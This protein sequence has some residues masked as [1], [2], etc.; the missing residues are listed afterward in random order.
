MANLV[1][2]VGSEVSAQLS[3]WKLGVAS[4]NFTTSVGEVGEVGEVGSFE[5]LGRETEE[6]SQ[7]SVWKLGVCPLL[8]TPTEKASVSKLI[9][10]PTIWVRNWSFNDQLISCA[11]QRHFLAVCSILR[12]EFF[13]FAA[14]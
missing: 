8:Y 9:Y 14:T 13:L 5:G 6:V 7:L 2:K 11:R 3:V 4:C 1:G 12:L 10:T